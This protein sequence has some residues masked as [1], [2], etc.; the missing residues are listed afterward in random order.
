M[1]KYLSFPLGS[2]GLFQLVSASDVILV[3]A[4]SS[5]ATKTY[6]HYSDGVVVEVVHVAQVGYSMRTAI[7]DAIVA[8]LTTP[9]QNVTYAVTPPQSIESV[10]IY[11]AP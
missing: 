6:I 2:T 10:G 9:W 8:A 1:Q 3:V 11:V 7:Q 5:T 4:A